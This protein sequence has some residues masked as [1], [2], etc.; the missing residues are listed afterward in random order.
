MLTQALTEP[1]A[2]ASPTGL[3]ERARPWLAARPVRRAASPHTRPEIGNPSYR[4][5]ARSVSGS[6]PPANEGDVARVGGLDR[7]HVAGR[8]RSTFPGA[9]DEAN[10]RYPPLIGHSATASTPLLTLQTDAH[11]LGRPRADGRGDRLRG[12]G[13]LAFP[14]HLAAALN[15]TDRGLLLRDVQPDILFHASS[16]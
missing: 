14:D 5:D 6:T 16:P 2:Y 1:L 15:N 8:N 9:W 10:V 13:A 7:R 3:P 4:A 12:G 11:R